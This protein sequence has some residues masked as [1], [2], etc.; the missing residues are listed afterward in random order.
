[1]RT[2]IQV[3]IFDVII[4]LGVFQG[5]MLSWFFIKNYR[6]EKRYNL[7][8]GLL[9]LS[10]SLAIFEEWL[11]NTGFIVR[12]LYLT[13]F[14]ESLNFTFA[15]LLYL[16]IRN[17]LNQESGKRAW[18]HFVPFFIWTLYM[19]FQFI[20][21]D[22]TKYNSY[23]QTKH[24]DW[25]FLEAEWSISD[26]PLGIRKIVNQLMLVQLLTYIA[27]AVYELG[28]KFRLLGQPLFRTENELLRT[29]RNTMIQFIS[30]I[31]LMLATKIYFG[32]RS[33]VG[34]YFIG[35]YVSL[36]IYITT[37]RIMN[38]SDYF[39]S[40]GSFL[41]FPSVKYQKSSLSEEDKERILAKVKREMDLNKYFTSNLASLAGLSKQINESHH[42]V[43]QVINEK[44]GKSFFEMLAFYRVEYA[45]KLIR[46]D[47][48]GKITIEELTEMVGYNS[49][50]S[51]NTAFK[52]HTS[53]TPS[54]FRKSSDS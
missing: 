50:S 37:W 44:L 32:M 11:N 5:L 12:V 18:W 31:I 40:P 41:S 22:E 20:Q 24:P 19:V 47:R 34:G 43:S 49:K 28:K 13:N 33:D 4:F 27:L 45:K 16:Y 8:Q 6:G 42:H 48:E 30:L 26:D 14:S 2:D 52:K 46:Q 36:L 25:G 29:L 1:M 23:I 15:P 7:F 9:L 17:S 51:F 53:K 10:M 38:K 35:A 3:S 39:E 21:P 54:E